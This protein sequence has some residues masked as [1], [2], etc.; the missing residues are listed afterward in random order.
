MFTRDLIGSIASALGLFALGVDALVTCG[1]A[2][3]AREP[4]RQ[5]EV[6]RDRSR[7]SAACSP[8]VSVVAYVAAY[9]IQAHHFVSH[10]SQTYP[11]ANA[12]LD[13]SRAS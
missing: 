5:A 8:G 10:G 12:L 13:R 2:R 7:W 4:E 1:G 11:E 6:H 9:G 3:A